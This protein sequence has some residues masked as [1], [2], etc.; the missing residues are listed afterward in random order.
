MYETWVLYPIDMCGPG[1]VSL[2]VGVLYYIMVEW[3][4]T[5]HNLV[6]AIRSIPG[7]PP[8]FFRHRFGTGAINV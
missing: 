7:S 5:W 6:A 1:D 2:L 8:P 3:G 4:Y